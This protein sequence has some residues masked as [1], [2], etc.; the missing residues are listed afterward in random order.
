[1]IE[2]GQPLPEWAEEPTTDPVVEWY[3]RAFFELCSCRP[4]GFGV[5]PVPWTAIAEYA[6]FSGLDYEETLVLVRAVRALDVVFLKW[7]DKKRDADGSR[8]KNQARRRQHS[9]S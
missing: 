3:L 8:G 2:R 7:Q 9:G 4:A 5:G 1:M 6:D